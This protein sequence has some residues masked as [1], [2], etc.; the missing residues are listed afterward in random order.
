MAIILF[1]TET[2][3]LL[4]I[5]LD[6]EADSFFVFNSNEQWEDYN[7]KL[8]W[9]ASPRVIINKIKLPTAAIVG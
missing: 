3:I 5:L 1:S 4:T 7:I 8:S 6:L 2:D 9:K